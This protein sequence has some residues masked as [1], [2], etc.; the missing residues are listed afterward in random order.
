MME[1]VSILLNYSKL[2]IAIRVGE[3]HFISIT[4]KCITY[5]FIE[6][7]ATEHLLI[8]KKIIAQVIP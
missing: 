6:W 4:T 5:L 7:V 3:H 1:K 8:Q 2:D